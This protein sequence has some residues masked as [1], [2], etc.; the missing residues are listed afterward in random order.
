MLGYF[1]YMYLVIPRAA[2]FPIL[3]FIGLEI[4]AQSFHATPKRHYA[5]LALACVPAMAKLV[6][7]F[8]NN[9]LEQVGKTID[10][11]QPPLSEQLQTMQMLSGGFVVTSLIWGSALAAIIDRR[12]RT[13]G[14]YF[15]VGGLC[16][17]FGVIHSPFADERL[18]L[19][20]RLGADLPR[21]AAGQTP[22]YMAASYLLVAIMLLVWGTYLQTAV[23]ARCL[24]NARPYPGAGGH[25]HSGR[26]EPVRPDGSQ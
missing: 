2:I 9:V 11:L 15:A 10:S 21:A 20:W 26:S 25:G 17:L 5:A 12:L 13:A 8:T 22:F 16:S 6:V 3:I 4:T 14:A 7:M 1:S 18:L 23:R 24:C 19:P